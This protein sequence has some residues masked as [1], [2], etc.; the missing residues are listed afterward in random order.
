MSSLRQS[1]GKSD[2]REPLRHPECVFGPRISKV[3]PEFVSRSLRTPYNKRQ[4]FTQPKSIGEIN[5]DGHDV[6]CVV[7]QV[8]R[9]F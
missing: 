5:D 1:P 3:E 2:I 6:Q 4:N 8:I 7:V 9:S